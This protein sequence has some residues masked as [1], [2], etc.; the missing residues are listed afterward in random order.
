MDRLAIAKKNNLV[1]IKQQM[2]KYQR[3]SILKE[4]AHSFFPLFLYIF[5][6]LPFLQVKKF[7]FTLRS[8]SLPSSFETCFL[9][10]LTHVH[11]LLDFAVSTRLFSSLT[12]HQLPLVSSNQ[13]KQEGQSTKETKQYKISFNHKYK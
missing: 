9:S 11:R 12:H 13:L 2:K 5:F 6:V 10:P 8:P 3:L 7:P 4:S 1:H